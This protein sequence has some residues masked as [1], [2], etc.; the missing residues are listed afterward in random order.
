M[1]KL[2]RDRIPE[3]AGKEADSLNS[4]LFILALETKLVEESLELAG[5]FT[6]EAKIEEA[7]DIM[8]VFETFLKAS[9]I[10]IAEVRKAQERKAQAK[11]RFDKHYFMEV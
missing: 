10:D 5:A 6:R 11:G 8:E 1:R 3:I 7:G 2:V 4:E 9:G